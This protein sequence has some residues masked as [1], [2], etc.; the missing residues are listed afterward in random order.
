[1]PNTYLFL[2]CYSRQPKRVIS[3]EKLGF[4]PP[5]Y[6]ALAIRFV[7]RVRD[8][9]YPSSQ[10]AEQDML[11]LESWAKAVVHASKT[12]QSERDVSRDGGNFEGGDHHGGVHARRRAMKAA[13]RQRYAFST[14]AILW[15]EELLG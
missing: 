5:P 9:L 10:M 2:V 15:A 14:T 12:D 8:A 4:C 3:C 1:M 7:S 6:V 13:V 11:W